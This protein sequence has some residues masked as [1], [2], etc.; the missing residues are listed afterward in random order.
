MLTKKQIE[1]LEKGYY[2]NWKLVEMFPNQ[3]GKG[4]SF[5]PNK[6]KPTEK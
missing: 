5:F 2:P 6:P 1:S 4:K 3:Q